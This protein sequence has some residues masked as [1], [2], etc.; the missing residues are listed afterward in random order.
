MI[1]LVRHTQVALRWR[2]RCYGQ[3]DVGLSRAGQAEVRAL[4]QSLA[5]WAPDR[6]LYSGLRRT[7]LLAVP[8]AARAGVACEAVPAWRERDFGSWEGRSWNAIYRETGNAMDGMID[9]P[10]TFRPGGGETTFDLAARIATALAMLPAGRIAI[11]THGGPIAAARGMARRVAPRDWPALVI[12]TGSHVEIDRRTAA[13]MVN[14][15][16][17]LTDKPLMP[18]QDASNG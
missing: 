14:R 6:V 4:A 16:Q 8:L 13:D 15:V 17:A 18:W 1:L 12:P 3:S 10:G 5:A 9:A 11:V 7:A 2:G